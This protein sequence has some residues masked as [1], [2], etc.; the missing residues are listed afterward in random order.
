MELNSKQSIIDLT[1]D[2]TYPRDTYGRPLVPDEIL[3]RMKKVTT[4]EAWGV[5]GG[6][7]YK[8]QFEGNWMNLH[9]ERILVGRAV[10]CRYVP[11]RADLQEQIQAEGER[12]GRVGGQNSWV[13]DT[14]EKGDVLVVELFGK[15]VHGTFIGDNLGSAIA[16]RTGGTG[17]VV[18]G[19]IRDA[20]RV[21]QLP[22]NVFTRGVHPS[23]IDD[24]TL[25]EINGPARIGEATVLP[26]D[27]VLGTP[28]GVIFVPPK[29]AAEVVEN[30][31]TTRMRDYFGKMRISEGIY[32]PGEVDRGWSDPMNADYEQWKNTVKLDEFDV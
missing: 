23:A 32:T 12:N 15:I 2:D 10:T 8:S 21:A 20:Q 11:R 28:T 13:I 6:H 7:G 3:E 5:I 19:S 25:V 18:D 30:S 22:I 14:L 26:G 16:A 31:E 1:P 9:P 27:V 4:E 17:L 29:L 24:V